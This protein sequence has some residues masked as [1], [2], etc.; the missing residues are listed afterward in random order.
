MRA[1]AELPS[2]GPLRRRQAPAA[3]LELRHH[4][5]S[6]GPWCGVDQANQPLAPMGSGQSHH[7]HCLYSCNAAERRFNLFGKDR[8]PTAVEGAIEPAEEIQAPWSE[9]ASIT[10]VPPAVGIGKGCT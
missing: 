8:G 1:G 5:I 6:I 2:L 9:A 7:Q 4:L 10:A 3:L